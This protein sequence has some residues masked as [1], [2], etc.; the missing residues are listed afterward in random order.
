MK[1]EQEAME[2]SGRELP[3]FRKKSFALPYRGGMIWFEHLDGL[4]RSCQLTLEKLRA[5]EP[6][7]HLPSAPGCVAFVLTESK[8]TP[9]ITEAL[10]RTLT[11]KPFRRVAFIGADSKVRRELSR[12]LASFGMAVCFETDVEKAKEWLI[13]EKA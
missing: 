9:E 6:A 7:F 5:D 12:R 3:G 11:E 2:T 10:V 13:P 1:A 8:I 4:G